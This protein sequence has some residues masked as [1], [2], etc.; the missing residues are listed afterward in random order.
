M[1]RREFIALLGGAVVPRPFA[2]WAQQP[3]GRADF[4]IAASWSGYK[5]TFTAALGPHLHMS[6][7]PQQG[8][9][10]AMVLHQC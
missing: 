3:G 10:H 2:A 6:R 9:L 5:G 7:V 8:G 1:K 4:R